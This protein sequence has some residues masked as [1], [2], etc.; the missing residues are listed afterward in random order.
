MFNAFFTQQSFQQKIQ[1]S[2]QQSAENLNRSFAQ[3]QRERERALNELKRLEQTLSKT[4]VLK[5]G[6]NPS[7]PPQPI[8]FK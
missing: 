6:P 3:A 5:P 4:I 7:A 2:Q 8:V 1:A